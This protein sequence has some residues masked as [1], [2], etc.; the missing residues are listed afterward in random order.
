MF[1]LVITV[2]VTSLNNPHERPA[3]RFTIP[4][5]TRFTC[6]E[7]Q[8]YGLDL[9]AITAKAKRVITI[10]HKTIRRIKTDCSATLPRV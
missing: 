4:Y 10:P 8:E 2:L 3:L 6:E 7:A 5:E 1:E 9:D